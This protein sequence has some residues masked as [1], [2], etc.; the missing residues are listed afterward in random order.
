MFLAA[1]GNPTYS[2]LL[3]AGMIVLMYF[4][5]LRPQKKQQQ[6]RQEMMNGMK[7][8]D[9]VITIG[10]LHGVIDEINN[11]D[12]TVTLD[13]E[14]VYLVFNANAIGK[15]LPRTEEAKV[16]AVPQTDAT[17]E[18]SKASEEETSVIA[19]DKTEEDK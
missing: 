13:C 5:I 9:R 19:E 17:D 1:Q 12:K 11:E 3:F 6:Q 14:G 8:G 15:V 2:I 7:R 4:T 18:T 16:A 10:G